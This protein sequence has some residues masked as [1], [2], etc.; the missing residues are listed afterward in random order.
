MGTYTTNLELYKP[1]V[2]EQGWGTMVNENFDKIDTAI[3]KMA[4]VPKMLITVTPTGTFIPQF[5]IGNISGD[6]SSITMMFHVLTYIPNTT[7]S[8]HIQLYHSNTTSSSTYWAVYFV[9]ED[10]TVQS[11]TTNN[12]S[13]KISI[14]SNT[15]YAF[16]CFASDADS[17]RNRIVYISSMT[18]DAQYVI[19]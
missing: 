19:S 13:S 18:F 5:S 16:A 12:S 3:S 14:P 15:T 6:D 10:G 2:G 11:N 8:G 4:V 7:Y 17:L 9:L 1:S